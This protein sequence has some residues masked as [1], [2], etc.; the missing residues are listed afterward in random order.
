MT[1]PAGM[2]WSVRF[3][4]IRSGRS[5]TQRPT[6]SAM[7]TRHMRCRSAMFTL[8]NPLPHE[9]EKI[10][11]LKELC[12]QAGPTLRAGAMRVAKEHWTGGGTRHLHVV[13]FFSAQQTLCPAWKNK[14]GLE[15]ADVGNLRSPLAAWN[16]VYKKP[17]HTPHNAEWGEFVDESFSVGDAC[18]AQGKRSDIDGPVE[19]LLDGASIREVAR[20]HPV[21]FVKYNRGFAALF[22]NLQEPRHLQRMPR[23]ITLYGGSGTGKS[24]RAWALS[25]TFPSGMYP[26]FV[27]MEKWWDGYMGEKAVFL[28]E[29]KGSMTITDFLSM[30]D[31]H[32]WCSQQKGTMVHMQADTFI[33]AS[34]VCPITWWDWTGKDGLMLQAER[35]LL[36]NPLSRIY[37]TDLKCFV[38]FSG[39]M[40]DPQPEWPD[41]LELA[42]EFEDQ[43]SPASIDGG[44]DQR[45]LS[46]GSR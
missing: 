19:A 34:P 43:V 37:S 12:E 35:R 21:Q 4:E 20:T 2:E 22:A 8:N 40:L 33:L 18:P 25:G 39:D 46:M 15:R 17:P 7:P 10:Y 31:K 5:E 32:P 24:D 41:W 13:V 6:L 29:F 45:P 44:L 23:C 14:Y 9:I 16:Y 42:K 11:G 30:I 1:W 3:F 38:N 27:S 28:D 36:E 26:K